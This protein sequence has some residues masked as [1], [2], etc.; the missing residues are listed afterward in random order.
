MTYHQFSGKL[1][2]LMDYAVSGK[3]SDV[4]KLMGQLCAGVSLKTTRFVDYALSLVED[5][6]GKRRIEYYLFHGSQIQRNY[7]SLYFNR[8]GDWK[9]VQ[10]AYKKGLIDE[11]QAFAR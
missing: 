11:I 5:D 8:R 7:S 2:E 1:K 3:K 6:E 4:D 9:I 10:E